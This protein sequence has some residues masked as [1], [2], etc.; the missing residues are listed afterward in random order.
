MTELNWDD[1]LDVRYEEG[2]EDGFE[3]GM[4]K[5]VVKEREESH[6]Y[7]LKLLDQGLSVDEIKQHLQQRTEKT[8]I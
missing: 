2:V 7:F 8:N 1:A 3:K 4:E 6:E 5:G